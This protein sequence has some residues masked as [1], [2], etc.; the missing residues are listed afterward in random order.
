[1]IVRK[2][3]EARNEKPKI[4]PIPREKK[5]FIPNER[6]KKKIERRAINK[7]RE[8]IESQRLKSPVSKESGNFNE[9]NKGKIQQKSVFFVEKKLK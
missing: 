2:K 8:K 5:L 6:T 7:R 1:M 3:A 9:K 4:E